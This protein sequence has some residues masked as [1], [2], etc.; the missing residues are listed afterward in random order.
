VLKFETATLAI[1]T[2]GLLA[3]A[4]GLVICIV[5]YRRT[6]AAG[7]NGA[8]R[9]LAQLHIIRQLISLLIQS[10]L[11]WYSIDL[12]VHR[13]L[14]YAANVDLYSRLALVRMA[15]TAMIAVGSMLALWMWRKAARQ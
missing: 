8:M 6:I 3:S 11:L 15:M 9:T 14:I 5:R 10:C 1:T 2:I 12:I 13:K 4:E 7:V